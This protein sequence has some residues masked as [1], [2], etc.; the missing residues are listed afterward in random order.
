MI[1]FI[2]NDLNDFIYEINN[3]NSFEELKKLYN[4]YK[5]RYDMEKKPSLDIERK[6]NYLKGII[7]YINCKIPPGSLDEDDF[8]QIRPYLD[9]FK[10]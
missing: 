3:C 4:H 9:K 1:K 8:S 10:I 5:I 7:F 6:Y 2:P